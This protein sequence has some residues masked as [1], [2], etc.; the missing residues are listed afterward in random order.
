MMTSV[1][2]IYTVIPRFTRLLW[3]P[4]NRVNR[5]SRYTSHSIDK[6]STSYVVS[7]G[8]GVVGPG[9]D[10]VIGL[11]PNRGGAVGHGFKSQ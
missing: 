8:C 1:L 5:I 2:H 4:K 6:K 10:D 11:S 7:G 9:K 3:Q